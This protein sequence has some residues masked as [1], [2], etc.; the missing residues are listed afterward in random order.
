[1]MNFMQQLKD[2]KTKKTL[3]T[4]VIWYANHILLLMDNRN[5]VIFRQTRDHLDKGAHSPH[6]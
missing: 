5:F 2:S 6:L 3:T 4:Y 1:M